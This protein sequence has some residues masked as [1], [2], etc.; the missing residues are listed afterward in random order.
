M[1]K[2]E[3]VSEAEWKKLSEEELNSVDGGRIDAYKYIN[4]HNK[5]DTKT[6]YKIYDND[7]NYQKM[8]VNLEE[9]IQVCKKN[10]WSTDLTLLG[11]TIG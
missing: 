1:I 6:L 10:G 2:K 4:N 11:P 7:G 9:A 5:K 8:F 3:N